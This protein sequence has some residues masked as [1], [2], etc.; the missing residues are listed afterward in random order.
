VAFRTW[1]L[2]EVAR[3]EYGLLIGTTDYTLPLLDEWRDE[4]AR[5]L[6]VAIPSREAYR[7]AYDK[8][9]TLELARAVGLAI[10]PTHLPRSMAELEKLAAGGRWPT[11][12]VSNGT[13]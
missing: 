1:L 12:K 4:L 5:H 13:W 9:A 11:P 7:R 3:G 2:Q 10:P 8:A 6:R